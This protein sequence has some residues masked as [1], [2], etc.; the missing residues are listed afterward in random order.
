MGKFYRFEEYDDENQSRVIVEFDTESETWSG[1]D[2]PMWKFFEFLKGCGYV[3]GQDAEIGV[4][5]GE[6][7]RKASKE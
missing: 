5:T 1:F 4:Q 3:F 2:G 7:F 6:Y